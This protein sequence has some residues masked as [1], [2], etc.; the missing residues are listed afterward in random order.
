[1]TKK[2]HNPIWVMSSAF[3]RLGLEDL[4]AV[5]QEIGVQGIDLCVFR[6]DGTRKDHTATH[7]DY[8][9]FTRDTTKRLIE[10]FNDAQL[11]LS[12]GAFENLIGGDPSE[13]VKNQNHLLKLIRIAYLLGGDSNDVKVGTFVGYNH[14]LGAE[15][16]GF[17][18]NLEEYRRV[19]AP[20][21]RYAEDLG[22]TVLYENC[23]MEGWRPASYTS[24]FNNLTGVLA[25][26]KLMYA[27]IP[28]KAHGEIYDPSHDVWQHTDPVEVIRQSDVLRIHRI[29]VKATRN[30]QT[31]A[32]TE[33]GGMYPMQLVDRKLAESAGVSIPAHD[34][35]RHHYEAML[36]GF[37]GSDSMDWRAFVDVLT[38]MGFAGPY[39]IENE[40]RNS[41]DTGNPGAIIQGFQSALRFLSPML[42]DLNGQSG[43]MPPAFNPLIEPNV[44]DIPVMT[45]E[46]LGA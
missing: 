8:D 25:A 27:L 20:I 34:W 23:P 4:I 19:F 30:L 37:G 22:V 40:A 38:E 44:K 14:E 10:R 11:R 15:E 2:R 24:T 12:V 43:Y 17:Q 9:G 46:K 5:A 3:D 33:W 36:P 41:K 35:D 6:R 26:R 28:S 31:K 16:Y 32:R 39:E 42:W 18:K 7:L 21:I 1:M 29:H 13:R 45:M